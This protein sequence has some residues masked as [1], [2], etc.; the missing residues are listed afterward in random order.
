RASRARQ[1]FCSAGRSYPLRWPWGNGPVR[2]AGSGPCD[3]TAHPY[4]GTVG[5][6][7]RRNRRM[8]TA[9][10]APAPTPPDTTAARAAAARRRVG[11]V[12]AFAAV[13]V[14]WGSTYLAI[15][16]AIETL[17]P[18]LMAGVRFL[19]SGAVLYLIGRLS[20]AVA[21]DLRQWAAG[22][23]AGGLMLWVGN[24]GVVFAE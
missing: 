7:R 18:F 16:V 23:V 14:L 21:P 4:D 9:R 19:F 8:A 22:A 6:P 10:L 12:L 13:Y 3:R 20:G 15:R 24:G 5:H 2:P 1:V 11:I 17:P